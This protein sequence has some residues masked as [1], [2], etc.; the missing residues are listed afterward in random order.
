MSSIEERLGLLEDEKSIRDLLSAYALTADHGLARQY[1]ELF[2]EDGVLDL[3]ALGA[4]SFEGRKSIYEDFIT[5]P[6]ATAA[7]GKTVHNS[8]PT[9]IGV[10]GDEAWAEGVITVALQGED[11]SLPVV[12]GSV[13]RWTFRRGSLGWEILRREF[14]PLGSADATSLITRATGSRSPAGPVR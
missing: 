5:Q 12:Q 2:A 1:A 10:E 9:V 14:V 4:G 3:T 13:N 6:I 11:G 7:V 8:A